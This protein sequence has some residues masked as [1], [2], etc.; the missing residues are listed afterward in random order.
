M[1]TSRIGVGLI[2]VGWMGRLHTRGYRG[3][4]EFF[5][6]LD[7]DVDLVVAADPV[8]SSARYAVDRLGYR[9][10]ASDY[11]DVLANPDVD[12]VSICSP[13]FLH[14]EIAVAAA[15]AGKHFW[16]EKPMGR[17]LAESQAIASA[18]AEA[19]VKTAVG[20]NYRHV[21]SLQHAR[22]L[23]RSGALGRINSVRAAFLADYAADPDTALSWRFIQAQSGPGVLSDL[24]SHAVDLAQYIVGPVSE[25]TALTEIFIK[26]RPL[27]ATQ[28]AVAFAKGGTEG[29]RGTVET[30]DY[31]ALLAR[32]AEGA[33]GTIEAS[34]AHVGPH[35]E[36]TIEIYGTEGSVRW[37]F[38]YMNELQ[39][40]MRQE[41]G[42]R[43]VR[44][45]PGQ[46]EFGRFQPGIGLS[47]GFDDLKT[48]E[49]YQFVRS[50][51]EDTQIAPSAEEG[52]SAIAVVQAALDSVSSGRWEKVAGPVRP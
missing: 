39:L 40:A 42:Y 20:F 15:K 49:A 34:R 5:P 24:M 28:G 32:F 50:V 2:S 27:P 26:E 3:I 1:T 41:A 22:D 45:A 18:A 30:D 43:T 31:A 12:V 9:S 25:V 33:V 51:I 6:E 44:A 35:A 4:C 13:N 14:H 17:S 11:R 29:P 8:E 38:H 21:P 16:I 47:M 37:N 10:A 7:V 19:G 52:R 48:I 36:Y 23:V 46:G